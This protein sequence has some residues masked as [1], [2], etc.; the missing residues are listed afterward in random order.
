VS[1]PLGLGVFVANARGP[2][3]LAE[4]V[5]EERPKGV[6]QRGRRGRS[7]GCG[8][9]SRREGSRLPKDLFAVSP[10]KS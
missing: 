3:T 2:E 5:K 10:M 9:N 7:S 8:Y 4:L 6:C 1:A